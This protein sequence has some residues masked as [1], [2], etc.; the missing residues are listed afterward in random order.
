MSALLAFALLLAQ[1]SAQPAVAAKPPEKKP[2]EPWHGTLA[3]G[4]DEVRRLSEAD[5]S[6][7]AL[8][9]AERL[10]SPDGFARWRERA[11][12]RPGW[13]RTIVEAADPL[14]AA[15]GLA[16]LAPSERAAVHFARG[17][18]LA[19]AGKHPEAT[20]A[21]ENAR[22]L[23]GPGDSRLDA[24]YDLGCTALV[25]GEAFRAQIPEL[26]G[27][28]GAQT[29]LAPPSPSI[30][31][32]PPG[33]AAP[34]SP[35][36]KPDPLELARAAY[37][38]A[39]EHLVER[40]KGDAQDADTRA[41][42]ELVQ[43]RLRELAEIQKKREE[44]KKK[45][46]QQKQDQQ[47]DD[48]NKQDKDSK[49]KDQKDKDKQD[50]QKKDPSSEDK[51]QKKPD[52]KPKDEKKDQPKDQESDEQKKEKKDAQPQPSKEEHLTKEEV[53]RLLDTLKDR[54]DEGKKLL[55]QLRRSR[56]AKVKK[57]W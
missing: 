30:P 52:E 47:K 16:E 40:L 39:R 37:L 9:V 36:D 57:D 12:A 44:E 14:L 15:I 53:I 1:A 6:E 33:S 26:N 32:A 31:P 18:V 23:A 28:A 25:V 2:I 49:D 4:L 21:F 13:K 20:E 55:E 41:N 43:K 42:V 19:H 34:G 56:R 46:E 38:E 35:P 7:E 5:K 29:A 3:Q 45:Q 50:P 11:T 22:A 17:V 24:T 8:D 51:D 54:E 10:L 27:G 48:P